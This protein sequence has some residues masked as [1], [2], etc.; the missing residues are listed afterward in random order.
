MVSHNA[1]IGACE[2][3]MHW[4]EGH[5]LLQEMLQRSLTST[6]ISYNTSIN[7]CEIGVRWKEAL[8]L[9]QGMS[10][11]SFTADAVSCLL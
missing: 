4:E 10:Y 6:V 8:R 11:R 3:G 9:L 5:R 2:K 7:T 1:C